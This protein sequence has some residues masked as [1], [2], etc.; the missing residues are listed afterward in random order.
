MTKTDYDKLR[1]KILGM[2]EGL[3]LIDKSYYDVRKLLAYAEKVH[4]N[5]RK[6]GSK[7]FSHQ[8][9]MLGLALSIHDLLLNPR[10]VYMAI[11]A[12]DLL[13]DYAPLE[14]EL[15][16]MQPD[17][18]PYAKK[19]AKHPDPIGAGMKTYN[20]YFELVS[21]CDVCSIVKLIDRV[22]NLSTAVGV[23]RT[24][25]LKEY[26]D[27]VD[28]YFFDM[29]SRAKNNFNQRQAYEVLK[30][31]LLI[32]CKTINKFHIL[33]QEKDDLISGAAT[34]LSA[35]DVMSKVKTKKE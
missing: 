7:E 16:A 35:S 23:F 12:H 11:I 28:A 3:A 21:S 27:E 15:L 29:I 24:E 32:E 8:L 14:P 34:A 1:T 5:L 17:V 18:V 25:K 10:M 19:L 33:L 2:L 22:H 13:E 31:M 26:V 30:S 20:Q 4:C 9:E 6:D